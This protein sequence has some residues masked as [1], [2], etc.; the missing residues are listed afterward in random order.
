MGGGKKG[1]KPAGGKEKVSCK[2]LGT[3]GAE[4]GLE[5]KGV[6]REG[7]PH[8]VLGEIK[9]WSAGQGGEKIRERG[10]GGKKKSGR[11]KTAK[12][13]PVDLGGRRAGSRGGGGD[14]QIKGKGE[15]GGPRHHSR[16]TQRTG[17]DPKSEGAGAGEGKGIFYFVDIEND[18]GKVGGNEKEKIK[19]RRANR[20]I[21]R[22]NGGVRRGGDEIGGCGRGGGGPLEERKKKA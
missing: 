12:T 1:R 14:E 7:S 17:G 2:G 15:R 21:M 10:V 19:E 13:R 9:D 4:K 5:E 20:T 11:G 22:G 3:A 18:G 16:H 8:K 6:S